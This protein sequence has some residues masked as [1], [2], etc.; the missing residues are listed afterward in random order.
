MTQFELLPDLVTHFRLYADHVGLDLEEFEIEEVLVPWL[1]KIQA[2]ATTRG[3]GRI[4]NTLNDWSHDT[5][6]KERLE[7][8][9]GL[10]DWFMPALGFSI[11]V[12]DPKREADFLDPK[13]G[14][15][16][17]EETPFY[18]WLFRTSQYNNSAKAREMQL[19]FVEHYFK[20][21]VDLI[22]PELSTGSRT[23]EQEVCSAARLVFDAKN[24]DFQGLLR[25]LVQEAFSCPEKLAQQIETYCKYKNTRLEQKNSNY[26]RSFVHFL[27]GDWVGGRHRNRAHRFN[28]M[29]A[30]RY[31]RTRKSVI[32][33]NDTSLQEILPFLPDELDKEGVQRDDFYPQQ[34]FIELDGECT[35]ERDPKELPA[36]ERIFDPVLIRKKSIDIT[37][38]VRR[39][40]NV[41]LQNTE[42]LKAGDLA[43]II[44]F[45]QR[46]VSSDYQ[47]MALV[48][49]AMLLIGKPPAELAQLYVFDDLKNMTSGLYLDPEG[50]GWWSFPITYSAKP[51]LGDEN[52]GL[53]ATCNHVF[54]SCPS[55]FV[56][57]LRRHYRGGLAPLLPVGLTTEKLAKR[58]KK[59]SD[60][61]P[62]GN[63]V[64]LEKLYSFTDRFCFAMES[65]DPVVLDFSYQLALSRTRVSRSY[66]CLDDELRVRSLG[67]LW[68]DITQFVRS[69]DPDIECPALFEPRQ[70]LQPQQLGSTFTPS[71]ASCCA[72]VTHLRQLLNELAPSVTCPLA[73]VID[74][75]NAY[76]AYTAFL[77]MFATGYRA[78]HNPLPSL[79]LHLRAYRLLGISDKD[80]SDFT[81]ARLVCMPE[82]LERQ[83]SYYTEHLKMLA[84]LLRCR[85]PKLADTVDHLLMVDEQLLSLGLSD[86]ARWYQAVRNS[87]RELG[88]LFHFKSVYRQWHAINLFPK[89]LS[90]FLPDHLTLP[91]NAG[92]HWMKSQLIQRNVDPELI[93]W[94]M[95][96]WMTGQAP[97]GYYSALSHVEVSRYL[98]PILDEMLKEVG[99]QP[100]PS[101][102]S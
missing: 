30:R 37:H 83:L 48:F 85:E 96:H 29:I 89:A 44:H 86:A 58:L 60:H 100:L 81:H 26:L 3:L 42:L 21:L 82:L 12:T 68:T 14:S 6:V 41:S 18:A 84:E 28:K 101:L 88:P 95:G 31:N 38:K 59:Y 22:D 15:G 35:L 76:A 61:L 93:D 78:V 65:I 80:D 23:R 32:Q 17:C 66:A 9:F 47:S 2:P 7:H 53:I 102:I 39:G 25:Y 63:R 74:Y 11:K 77:L 92:R 75:H 40:Q 45:L 20:T 36:V 73:E 50:L 67:R 94:Q 97:L 24:Q 56:Q 71:Q 19:I 8:I 57:L 34:I 51:R 62:S 33:G 49:W 55:F 98:A 69:A 54:T 72:L 16:W 70:W 90:G 46:P 4:L 5:A 64:S 52:R 13:M 87:R 27:L 43:R 79:A 10:P 91:T 99:W 1:E